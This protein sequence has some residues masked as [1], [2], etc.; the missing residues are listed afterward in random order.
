MIFTK[1]ERERENESHFLFTNGWSVKKYS[2]VLARSIIAVLAKHNRTLLDVQ[3]PMTELQNLE[4]KV[5]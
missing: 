4:S 2:E 1:R 5:S 3:I